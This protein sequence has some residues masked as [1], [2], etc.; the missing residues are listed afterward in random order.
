MA[1]EQL[2]ISSF[3][4]VFVESFALFV[5]CGVVGLNHTD[6]HHRI[7][8]IVGTLADEVVELF[9][10][11]ADKLLVFGH[12]A[13]EHCLEVGCVL[14]LIHRLVDVGRCFYY[15]YSVDLLLRN[16]ILVLVLS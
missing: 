15:L 2:R 6:W 3:V 5:V 8:S 16:G 10:E 11:G 4:K 13:A 7:F 12:G 1:D 14:E 9:I